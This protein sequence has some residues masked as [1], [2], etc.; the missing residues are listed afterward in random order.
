MPPTIDAAM[1]RIAFER[2]AS[3]TTVSIS[4]SV[5]PVAFFSGRRDEP[6]R[7]VRQ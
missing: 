2:G 1:R 5:H 3:C 6:F 4:R 7:R